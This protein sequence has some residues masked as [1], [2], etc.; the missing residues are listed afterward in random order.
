MS[1]SRAGNHT[2]SRKLS[3]KQ[4]YKSQN[5]S[6]S[7]RFHATPG[8]SAIHHFLRYEK[9]APIKPEHVVMTALALTAV[10]LPMAQALEEKSKQEKALDKANKGTVKSKTIELPLLPTK[11]NPEALDWAALKRKKEEIDRKIEEKRLA[12]QIIE[13]MTESREVDKKREKKITIIKSFESLDQVKK[14][15]RDGYEDHLSRIS[16]LISEVT[17]EANHATNFKSPDAT[18]VESNDLYLGLVACTALAVGSVGVCMCA[19]CG[20]KKSSPKNKQ[21]RQTSAQS[22]G[23]KNRSLKSRV[24]GVNNPTADELL[25]DIQL[26][27]KKLNE[28]KIK[29]EKRFE[30]LEADHAVAQALYTSSSTIQDKKILRPRESLSKILDRQD[31]KEAANKFEVDVEKL[32][33]LQIEVEA[34]SAKT[35]KAKLSAVK[36]K[37]LELEKEFTTNTK[38]ATYESDLA[39][40][41]IAIEELVPVASRPKRVVV[42]PVVSSVVQHAQTQHSSTVESISVQAQ[43]QSTATSTSSSVHSAS[44]ASTPSPFTDKVDDRMG[45]EIRRKK[46]YDPN[47]GTSGSE[48]SNV[49]PVNVRQVAKNVGKTERLNLHLRALDAAIALPNREDELNILNI[50]YHLTKICNK[51]NSSYSHQLQALR[52]SLV[53]PKLQPSNNWLK[54]KKVLLSFVEAL[55]RQDKNITIE[56]ALE[57]VIQ[58]SEV[59]KLIGLDNGSPQV[60]NEGIFGKR[61]ENV[62]KMLISSVQSYKTKFNNEDAAQVERYAN[63]IE[64]LIMRIAE[65]IKRLPKYSSIETHQLLD[66]RNI[67]AHEGVLTLSTIKQFINVNFKQFIDEL[68]LDNNCAQSQAKPK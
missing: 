40:R 58:I 9:A 39:Q 65:I 12:Q 35:S 30:K 64:Y 61:R 10:M 1:K 62:L 67:V 7:E 29:I 13:E 11:A 3:T 59:K 6:T 8:P 22:Q 32:T 49:S 68:K 66:F 15:L 19:K 25:H 60:S 63:A 2:H 28:I 46:N 42:M 55:L 34:L 37:L 50:L 14:M 4:V 16:E 21:Q 57:N 17:E 18:V 51:Y 48:T 45:G 56:A 20:K 54:Q 53:H 38:L 26:Q 31:R 44:V 5:L 41:M 52:L 24:A 43:L 23:I 33:K 36:S 47:V 27:L